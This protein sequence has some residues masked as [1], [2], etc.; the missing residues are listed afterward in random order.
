MFVRNTRFVQKVIN[1]DTG[2]DKTEYIYNNIIK[3]EV[4]RIEH[5]LEFVHID[6]KSFERNIKHEEIINNRAFIA[7]YKLFSPTNLLKLPF[8]S[9]H[10]SLNKNFYGELLY[11]M[12]VEEVVDDGV[13]KIKRL[14]NKRQNFSL[15]EQAYAKLEDY[16]S[17]TDD[18]ERFEVALSLVLTWINRI[19]FLKLLESQL[20]SFN[21]GRDVKFLDTTHILDYDVLHD[22][23][24]KVMAKPVSERT[25]ELRSQFPDVP[26]LN[27]SLFELAKIE[28]SY[29]PI[30]GIRL[31]EMEVYAKTVL[32][33][34]NGKRVTGRKATLEYLF[35]FLDAYDFGT[36]KSQEGENVRNE[37]DK[38]IN[39]SVL[40]LIFEKINGYKDGSFFTPGYITE[41]ICNKTLRRAVIDKFNKAKGWKCQDFEEL[42]ENINFGQRE[43][44]IEANEIINSLR[45]C[46][47][48][49]GSGHFLVSALNELIAIKSELGV[50]QDRQP[51]PKRIREYDIRV[52]YDELVVADEDGDIFKYDPSN[53]SSQRIQETLFEEKR[54]I[55]ENCLFGVDLNPKSVDI[56]QLRLWIELLKNAYYYKTETGERLL[57]TLPNIDINIK[58]GNSLASA[59]PVCIGR[60]ITES[61]GM[62]K[63]VRDYKANVREYK[64]CRTKAIKNRLDK[65]I[66]DIKLKLAP[67]VQLNAF[68]N[69]ND[70]IIDTQEILKK[71]L[72]WMVEF[73]EVLNE[74]GAF[75]GFDVIIGNPPYI[76]LEKLRKDAYVYSKMHRTDE[77]GHLE[78]KT[79]NTLESRGDIYSLFVERG[80]HLLRKGGH[81]SY[82]MPNKWEKVMYGR[83][84]RELFLNTNLS[85]LIDFGDNQIFEDATT[86]TCIIRMKKERQDHEILVSTIENINPETLHEDVEEEKEKFDTTR[87]SDDIWVIS[88]L[89]NFNAVERLKTQ[90]TTLGEF[91]G[92]ESYRGILSGLSKAFNIS[93]EKANELI[94]QD[95][96][97]KDVVRPFLQGRGLV[98][99]GE[100]VAGS[101]LIFTPKGFTLEG[102]GIEISDEEKK[103]NKNWKTELM[104]S[105]EEA[106]LWFSSNYSAVANWLSFFK[107]EA[108]KRQDKG[109]YWW[110]LRACDYYDQFAKHKLFYQVFQTKPCFVYDESSTFCNNSMYFMTVPDKALM[111]LLCSKIGWWLIT[112][113]CP[114]IQNGAQLIWDNFRQIPIPQE[115]PHTLN[116]Y[117]DKMMSAR[118]D[119]VEFQRL[120]KE[121]DKIVS[122][123][124]GLAE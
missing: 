108:K 85:Q 86:Y 100:A 90:M 94:A 49:V 114:R 75:E 51:Q 34:G 96:R 6:L 103:S 64:N 32:K 47:P 11:I 77:Q 82:I 92:G 72:E 84:L 21:R 61:F 89:D 121:I 60:K 59:H 5:R 74:Q 106:W 22:L 15:V 35:S 69:D 53:P 16:S 41:Y 52:E 9:D 23:F 120:S 104:P 116:E 50:L 119:E 73:P 37:S 14:R 40:G 7:V 87:M 25:D 17:I 3:P 98:A 18:E 63:L 112:E 117:A 83:P 8:V 33:D 36:D 115:L 105:E 38:L 93:K 65:D 44:R 110:E 10:N 109:D 68:E 81:L 107:K 24:M 80:L 27:S 99:Y 79:Y 56:C 113:F 97:S 12:G 54:T 43:E 91:V 70:K 123:L 95:Y 118:N 66:K 42:K 29:F 28:E 20:V 122:S 101:Y 88:S 58:C 71:S 45:I 1:A 102:M 13:H 76:S 48:A 26:Y 19:L 124:Y 78:Q 30:S 31:G 39:A 57:Q 111:A 46:D 67:P 4:E 62:Q 2:D 55:I